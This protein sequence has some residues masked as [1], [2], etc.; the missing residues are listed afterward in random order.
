MSEEKELIISFRQINNIVRNDIDKLIKFDV[1]QKF[2]NCEILN[3]D[4]FYIKI[5]LFDNFILTYD[6]LLG[7]I[8][9]IKIDFNCHSLE[10]IDELNKHNLY[11]S[12]ICENLNNIENI[13]RKLN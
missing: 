12:F 6:T 8:T 13:L 4:Q 9:D 10:L 1:L 2:S 7:R 11:S 3:W 5:K